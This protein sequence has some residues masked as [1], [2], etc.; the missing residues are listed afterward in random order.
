MRL[1]FS[2]GT[3]VNLE[4]YDQIICR[5]AKYK[6][7]NV[8]HACTCSEIFWKYHQSIK[9]FTFPFFFL[10]L[11]S[12][13]SRYYVAS[14]RKMSH[15]VI[16]FRTETFYSVWEKYWHAQLF[17]DIFFIKRSDVL[18]KSVC[19]S[20]L[21]HT[22]EMCTKAIFSNRLYNNNTRNGKIRVGKISTHLWFSF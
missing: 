16:K 18:A 17:G 5:S 21:L 7:T 20:S 10:F 8:T 1:G 14:R 15:T 3:V 9:F 22:R 11:F 2:Q 13:F 12:L 6:C 4:L 19:T